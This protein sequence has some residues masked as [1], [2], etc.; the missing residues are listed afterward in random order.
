MLD[1]AHGYSQERFQYGAF[2]LDPQL[3]PSV[4]TPSHHEASIR[5]WFDIAY[6]PAPITQGEPSSAIRQTFVNGIFGDLFD[7]VVNAPKRTDI[8]STYPVLVTAGEIE[9]TKEYG[10]ALR[11]YMR[12][13]GTLVVCAGQLTGDGVR[14]LDLPGLG[15]QAEADTFSWSPSGAMFT[16]NLFRYRGISKGSYRELAKT[17]DGSVIAIDRAEGKGQLIFVSVPLGL[18]IDDRPVPL[19]AVL[20]QALASGQAPIRV[21]GDV[22]W[23][24]NRLEDGGWLVTIL[25]NRGV[26]KPQHGILPTDQAEAQTVTLR[27]QF[28]VVQCSEWIT[29]SAVSWQVVGDASSVT[30]TVPAGATRMI[31]I[32][33][34]PAK[35]PR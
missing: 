26:N 15:A 12:R 16:S 1:E 28:A 5:G 20:M 14:D 30:L 3:N 27:T 19:L 17:P 21:A 9:I 32:R 34:A 18:G 7:V 22:E 35:V 13:G 4:L 10:A 23:V 29:E 11:D 2:G 31:E 25:N 24:L 6:Y 33:P 8:L